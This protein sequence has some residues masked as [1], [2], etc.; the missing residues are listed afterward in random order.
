MKADLFADFDPHSGYCDIPVQLYCVGVSRQR[1]TWRRAVR[2]VYVD[3]SLRWSR[4]LVSLVLVINTLKLF[5]NSLIVFL[6]PSPR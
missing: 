5:V 3:D 6:T 4:T 1:D 2:R